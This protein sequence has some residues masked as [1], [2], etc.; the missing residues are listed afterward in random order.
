M[1]VHVQELLGRERFVSLV[2]EVLTFA[3]A[4]R[5]DYLDRPLGESLEIVA[6]SVVVRVPAWGVA[7]VRLGGVAV[8]ADWRMG[9]SADRRIGA[10]KP[11]TPVIGS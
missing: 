10:P 2:G 7:A 5:V 9:G 11:A 1:I 3:E 4:H 6:H 8:R